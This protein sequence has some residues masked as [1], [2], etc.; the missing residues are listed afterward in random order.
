M[1]LFASLLPS[2]GKAVVGGI[3]GKIFGGGKP[4]RTSNSVD[5]KKLVRSA[6]AAGFNPLTALRNG[7]AGQYVADAIGQGIDT[8]FNRDQVA[9][10]KELQRLEIDLRKE[11]LTEL[12]NRN[13]SIAKGADYGY[14]IPQKPSLVVGDA[15]DVSQ[16]LNGDGVLPRSRGSGP[17]SGP[18]H[19]GY[20][21]PPAR[22]IYNLYVEVYDS[23]TGHWITIPNPDL[24]DA[25]PVESAYAMG[26]LG[27]ADIAQNGLGLGGVGSIPTFNQSKRKT[28]P[29]K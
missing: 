16:D 2:V 26:I 10:D 1:S 7:G 22:D 24:M 17:T 20:L 23:Q 18:T 27:A 6:Q 11:E 5:Y 21:E 4:Q 3:A 12:R 25:G 28:R 9:A 13:Q 8:Y 14:R 15:R 19:A 29:R